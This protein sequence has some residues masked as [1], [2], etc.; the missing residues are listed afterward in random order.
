MLGSSMLLASHATI[1]A[2][3]C[4]DF[5]NN[6]LM[7]CTHLNKHPEISSQDDCR[8]LCCDDPSCDTWQWCPTPSC[9]LWAGSHCWTGQAGT[10]DNCLPKTHWIGESKLAPPPFVVTRKKGFSGFLGSLY[11]CDD[12][13]VLGL[14][15]SWYYSWLNQPYGQ[16]TKCKNQEM[17]AE[18]V[19]MVIGLGVADYLLNHTGFVS[20]WEATHSRFLLGYNEPDYGNGHNHPHMCSP[21]DAAADW[22]KVQTIA[23]MFDPPLELVSPAISNSGPDALDADG[24]SIWLD[25]FLGNCSDVVPDCDP[26]L[27]KHVAFHDYQGDPA[28]LMR[29]VEGGYK[30]Y[31]RPVWLTEFAV[32]HWTSGGT[33]SREDQDKYLEAVLPMLEA[34]DAVFRYAWFSARSGPNDGLGECSLLPYDS[35]STELTSTGKIY[36]S[37]PGSSQVQLV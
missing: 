12:A 1:A 11:T 22:P 14:S 8:Q 26:S 7:F 10:Y 30:K 35:N 15:D 34:S 5:Q 3:D 20:R 36:A 27:I 25:Q 19:P 9:N 28:K 13:K 32:M 33:P 31:G 23:A 37:G 4:A 18:F 2:A 6:D 21:A 24:G 16:C 29:R 17:A